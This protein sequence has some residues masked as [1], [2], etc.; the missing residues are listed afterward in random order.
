M[1]PENIRLNKKGMAV[2][3]WDVSTG[4]KVADE[5]ALKI[6]IKIPEQERP[7]FLERAKLYK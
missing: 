3:Y 4:K 7:I 2:Y 1:K 6:T 5:I